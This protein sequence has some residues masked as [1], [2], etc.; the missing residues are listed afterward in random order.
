MSDALT[1]DDQAPFLAVQGISK[2]FDGIAALSGV[3]IQLRACRGHALVGENGAGK[4]TLIKIVSGQLEPDSGSILLNGTKVEFHDSAEALRSGI[5]VVPQEACLVPQLSVAEN[6]FLGGFP[7]RNNGVDFGELHR[8]SSEVLSRL[9]MKIDP[10]ERVANLSPGSQRLIE[11]A[12]GLCKKARLFVLDEPTAALT[13]VESEHMFRIL[14]DLKAEGCAILYVSHRM[15]EIARVA[16]DITVLR[17]GAVTRQW[18]AQAVPEDDIVQAMV[19]RAIQKF[20]AR[21]INRKRSSS[22]E[23]LRV[24]NLCRAGSIE[25]VSFSVA[26]GEILALSGLMGAGRTEILRSIF[27][28]DPLDSGRIFLDGE[29]IRIESASDAIKA[30][31]ALVPEE[32]KTQGV[33]QMMSIA[34]NASLPHF[35]HWA[36]AGFLQEGRRRRE[37]L[38]FVRKLGLKFASIDDPVRN[39]SGGNQQKVVFAKWLVRRPKVFL[40]DEPTRGIDVGAKFEVHKLVRELADGGCAVVLVSSE[41][42]EVLGLAD[43]ILVIRAGRVVG[44][45]DAF[46]ATEQ[47][48]VGLAMHGECG[49]DTRIAT[50]RLETSS[51]AMR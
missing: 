13:E 5:S 41:L 42:P 37:I 40:L 47:A 22:V 45:M 36:H 15:R 11:I 29:K 2:R 51:G 23:G 12:R 18:R 39:L 7:T 33:V 24:E 17:D 21:P 20:D 31:L 49:A 50:R 3:D 46:D 10:R 19:G 48:L 4:S 1:L 32:R 44:E 43:R 9:G 26:S 8:R 38:E 28:L 30:G 25:N 27:G 16:E 34:D 14:A 35:S 6:I